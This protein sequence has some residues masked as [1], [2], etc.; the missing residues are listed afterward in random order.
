M[1]ELNE[2]WEEKLAKTEAIQKER[3]T[4]L[5]EMGIAIHSGEDGKALGVFMPKKVRNNEWKLIQVTCCFLLIIFV[6]L[7]HSFLLLSYILLLHG[8]FS[9][10]YVIFS[11][12][13]FLSLSSLSLS[14]SPSSSLPPSVSLPQSPHL[15]NLNEDPLMSECLLYYI[16]E[17]TTEVGQVGDIQLSGE[18]ILDHH[19]SLICEDG[20]TDNN[21]N[22]TVLAVTNFIHVVR[23]FILQLQCICGVL[24][25]WGLSRYDSNKHF[26]YIPTPTF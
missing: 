26:K 7:P 23:G 15:V 20:K 1:A 13:H 17:G 8:V 11:F 2:T 18:F 3:E 9:F 21:N 6:C 10:D 19:C 22:N 24:G 25:I 12:I 4:T 5:A 16:K 14:P